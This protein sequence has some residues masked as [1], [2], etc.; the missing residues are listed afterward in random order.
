MATATA[1]RK[2]PLRKTK[3]LLDAERQIVELEKKLAEVEK[4]KDLWYRQYIEQKDITDGIHEILD[5]LDIKGYRD[6]NKSQRLPLPV[7]LF[8]WALRTNKP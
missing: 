6:E 1:P 5:D 2:A 3:A 4:Y 7:R 8:A